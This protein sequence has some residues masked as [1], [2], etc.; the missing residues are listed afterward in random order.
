MGYIRSEELRPG[1]RLKND[2]ISESGRMFLAGDTILT[3]ILI[4]RMKKNSTRYTEIIT[5][6][7]EPCLTV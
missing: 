3:D 6:R 1:M 5:V 7:S 2:L 4:N